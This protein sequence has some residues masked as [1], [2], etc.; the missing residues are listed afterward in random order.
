MNTLERPAGGISIN[1]EELLSLTQTLEGKKLIT[2]SKG[3]F[4]PLVGDII[5]LAL[6]DNSS[7][8]GKVTEVNKDKIKVE[9]DAPKN[10]IVLEIQP[11]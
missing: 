4:A 8:I 7:A 6:P 3:G 1:E 10:E 9:G 2:V 11:D 5:Q